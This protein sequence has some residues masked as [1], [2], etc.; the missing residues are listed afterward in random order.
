MLNEII[1]ISI[2]DDFNVPI[3]K[4][5]SLEEY[6]AAVAESFLGKNSIPLN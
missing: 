2:R 6:A 1:T 3:A 4:I 5:H